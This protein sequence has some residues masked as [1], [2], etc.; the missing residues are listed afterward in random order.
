VLD[1][2][3]DVRP[4]SPTLFVADPTKGVLSFAS[5]NTLDGNVAPATFIDSFERLRVSSD[6]FPL[7]ALVLAVDRTGTLIVQ[8]SADELRFYHGA[9]TVTGVPAPDRVI[10]GQASRLVDDGGMAYD[11]VNDRL[12]VHTSDRILVFEG[13]A[14]SQDGEIAPKREFFNSDFTGS[15]IA[16]GPNGDLYVADGSQS[17]LVVANP[18]QRSG[19]ITPDREIFIF[20][21]ITENV[22]VDA[23]DRLYVTDTGEIAVLA[24]ASTLDGEIAFD[25]FPRMQLSGVRAID[26]S[27]SAQPEIDDIVIDSRGIGYVADRANAAIHVID[28]IAAKSGVIRTDRAIHGPDVQFGRPFALFLWE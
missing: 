20:G 27:G 8:D 19:E 7:T 17:V 26:E 1:R 24:N 25:S 2:S 16:L 28:N 11:R 13:A 10:D 15:S 4:T 5:A 9:A 6:Q 12:F 22:F 21:I 3:V 23:A 18:A 14:L